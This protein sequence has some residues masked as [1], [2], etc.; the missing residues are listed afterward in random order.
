MK[1]FLC[2]IILT[3]NGIFIDGLNSGCF[4]QIIHDVNGKVI[5]YNKFGD[6]YWTEN[7]K[8][9]ALWGSGLKLDEVQ[10][11]PMPKV[12]LEGK[13][14]IDKSDMPKFNGRYFLSS[15]NGYFYTWNS[16]NNLTVVQNEVSPKFGKILNSNLDPNSGNLCPCGWRLPN[17]DDVG[18]L[19]VNQGYFPSIETFKKWA[20]DDGILNK[21]WLL[22]PSLTNALL[23]T[24]NNNI[25]KSFLNSSDFGGMY[26]MMGSKPEKPFGRG[27]LASFWLS[28]IGISYSMDMQMD[29]A[30]FIIMKTKEKPDEIAFMLKSEFS[31]ELANVRC[32]T[33]EAGLSKYK[34]WY[35]QNKA[36]L[37]FEN[38]SE[39]HF[40]SLLNSKDLIGS[41]NYIENN[42]KNSPPKSNVLSSANDNSEFNSY[43][44]AVG[45]GE[46]IK[47]KDGKDYCAYNR[48]SKYFECGGCKQKDSDYC[49]A[50]NNSIK[51]YNS[52]INL[53]SKLYLKWYNS[54][55]LFLGN[56]VENDQIEEANTYISFF[57][58]KKITTNLIEDKFYISK[59]K[60]DILFAKA[61]IREE[62]LKKRPLNDIE[63]SFI[64]IWEFKSNKISNSEISEQIEESWIINSDRTYLYEATRFQKN[65]ALQFSGKI[66]EVNPS[67][68]KI[69][70]SYK[71]KGVFEIQKNDKNEIILTA[72]INEE[73]GILSTGV[74]NIPF[75]YLDSQKA[76]RIFLET[77]YPKEWVLQGVKK[78]K[79]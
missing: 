17:I 25:L 53:S 63:K 28:N 19:L 69:I 73:N 42:F 27:E 54:F 24:K 60:N 12:D 21:K 7:L 41:Y 57:E 66:L 36:N 50:H 40:D 65:K 51:K 2:F 45:R 13:L 11:A 22:N 43:F 15:E 52:N 68:T 14:F 64:G 30:A 56:L 34:K 10:S 1:N 6:Y 35:E 47:G 55:I 18:N 62:E 5:D 39:L 61:R 31:T 20:Y 37:K 76:T 8:S 79:R 49:L 67:D 71:E 46:I 9:T 59:W 74:D 23:E 77:G 16:A 38:S 48:C 4:S 72:Y 26:G 58:N 78:E 75:K 3:L 33:D 44:D 29:G 32:I 70:E